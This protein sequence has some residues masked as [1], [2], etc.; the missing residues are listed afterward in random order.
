MANNDLEIRCPDGA[1]GK[2]YPQIWYSGHTNNMLGN[3]E[4]FSGYQWNYYSSLEHGPLRSRA[5]SFLASVNWAALLEYAAEKNNGVSCMLLSDIGLGYNH[6]VRIIQFSDGN[7]MG[8]TAAAT[9]SGRK[10]YF[11]GC[12]GDNGRI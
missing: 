10:R 1:S 5:D 3:T 2:L 12:F 6:M 7:Q 8:G 11:Q 4:G 9:S